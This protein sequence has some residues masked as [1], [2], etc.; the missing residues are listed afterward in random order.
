MYRPSRVNQASAQDTLAVAQ[1]AVEEI[2]AAHR[3]GE[4]VSTLE[5]VKIC[6]PMAKVC[7]SIVRSL[8]AQSVTF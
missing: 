8:T 1:R 3:Q 6:I 2:D 4:H 7:N 5:V